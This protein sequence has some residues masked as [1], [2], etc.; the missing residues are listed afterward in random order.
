MLSIKIIIFVIF[1]ATLPDEF[2]EYK[3]QSRKIMYLKQKVR[4]YIYLFVCL[5]D[6][7]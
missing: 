6:G 3:N 7:V 4:L 1:L 5:F 2:F